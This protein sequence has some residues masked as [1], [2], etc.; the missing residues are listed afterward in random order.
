MAT[1]AAV[2]PDADREFPGKSS[3]D[4]AFKPRAGLP[5]CNYI[6]KGGRDAFARTPAEHKANVERFLK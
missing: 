2:E 4:T 3:L 5:Y 1:L 6:Y